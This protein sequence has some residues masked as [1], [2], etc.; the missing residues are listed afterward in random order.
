MKLLLV[1]I[2]YALGCFAQASVYA[3]SLDI[4]QILLDTLS[5]TY[6]DGLDALCFG[7]DLDK[8]IELFEKTMWIYASNR[9]EVCLSNY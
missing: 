8:S 2:Y 7:N 9:K 6:L 4:K 5:W 3:K 1:R